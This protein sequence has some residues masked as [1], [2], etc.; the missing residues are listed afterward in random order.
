M[1]EIVIGY[2]KECFEPIYLS[3]E[4]PIRTIFECRHCGH[5][6]CADEIVELDRSLLKGNKKND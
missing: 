6:H 1:S 4:L 3:D 2:C 5:P